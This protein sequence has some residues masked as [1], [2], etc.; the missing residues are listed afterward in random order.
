MPSLSIGEVARRTGIRTSALRYYEDAGI[1]PRPAR[2]NGRRSYDADVIRRVDGWIENTAAHHIMAAW[3]EHQSLADPIEFPQKME[4]A[5]HHAVALQE[6]PTACDYAYRI[7]AGVGVDTEKSFT[8][9]LRTSA[10]GSR[11]F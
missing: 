2:V 3:L 9:G 6:R 11:L 7:A 1:L 5:L 8:H 4:P 10:V